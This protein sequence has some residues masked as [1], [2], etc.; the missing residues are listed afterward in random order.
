M[1]KIFFIFT[2]FLLVNNQSQSNSIPRGI[3]LSAICSSGKLS[4]L[5][6][7]KGSSGNYKSVQH[8][9]FVYY[10]GYKQVTS[11]N[12]DAYVI[13]ADSKGNVCWNAQL[14]GKTGTSTPDERCGA[15]ALDKSGQ[16]LY[17][18]CST[19]G[20]SSHGF[21][22]PTGSRPFSSSYGSGGGPKV[23]FLGK[24]NTQTGRLVAGTYL[25]STITKNG[26]PRTNTLKIDKI[27]V[28]ASGEVEVSG[29]TAFGA[30]TAETGV[31]CKGGSYSA[32]FNGSLSDILDTTCGGG[33]Y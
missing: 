14:T 11:N 15:L 4:D 6:N 26:K 8:K 18:A 29:Q 25:Q 30:P 5:P 19:D 16:F 24:I 7:Y 2:I 27:L 32:R 1:K 20:G 17:V 10:A 21:R 3:K 22:P 31:R 9:G 23:T 13:K 33:T 12:Q 28:D